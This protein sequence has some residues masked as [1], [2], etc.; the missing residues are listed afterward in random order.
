MQV[1]LRVDLTGL[2]DGAPWPPRG[3]LLDLPDDE[4]AALCAAGIADPVASERPPERAVPP[5]DD[6]QTRQGA[7]P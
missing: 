3:H 5:T 7:R 4:A 2:R 1:R 6:V